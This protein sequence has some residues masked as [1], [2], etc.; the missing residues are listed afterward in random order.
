MQND[1]ISCNSILKELPQTK[2]FTFHPL[3][4]LHPVLFCSN[5]EHKLPFLHVKSSASKPSR[6][7]VKKTK[8]RE[9]AED[10][11]HKEETSIT[12]RR[13][14]QNT[15]EV[16]DEDEERE[17]EKRRGKVFLGGGQKAE[18]LTGCSL[19]LKL[20]LERHHGMSSRQKGGKANSVHLPASPS[21]LPPSRPA[22]IRRS[23]LKNQQPVAL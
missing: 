13:Q 15:G 11:L 14:Q 5:H 20:M 23:S 22:L 9:Q 4:P 7:H 1:V 2:Q 8:N 21:L 6:H 19:S 16:R 18:I 12:A 17:D 10:A 3:N